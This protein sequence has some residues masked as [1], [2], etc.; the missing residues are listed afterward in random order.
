MTIVI[1]PPYPQRNS[2]NFAAEADSWNSQLPTWTDQVNATA[3]DVTSKASTATTQAEI[4]TTQ[5][6]LATTQVS[7]AT[8]QANNAAI[9]A[10]AASIT[11]NVSKWTSGTTYTEGQNVW[12]PITYYTYRRKTNGAGTTDPS[13][14]TTNWGAIYIPSPMVL[15]STAVANNVTAIDFTGLSSDYYKYIVDYYSVSASGSEANLLCQ[16][17]AGGSWRTI[18]YLGKY[19][20]NGHGPTSNFANIINASDVTTTS[21]VEGSLIIGQVENTK[22]PKT[23]ETTYR[24]TDLT[25]FRKQYYYNSVSAVT[26]LRFILST[27]NIATGTFKLYGMKV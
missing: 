8:T 11:A 18:D 14:D 27:G 23:I 7:L 17:N 20:I 1:V 5:A 16:V 25:L 9:S 3:V 2:P 26:G 12:S 21:L 10:E 24:L 6:G 13:L 4:A 19:V 22:A 15:I